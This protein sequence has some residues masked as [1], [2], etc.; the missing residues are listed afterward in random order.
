MATDFGIG[1]IRVNGSIQRSMK[2]IDRT[3]RGAG[4]GIRR[5]WRAH[6]QVI[7]AISIVV[8]HSHRLAKLIVVVDGKIGSPTWHRCA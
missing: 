4:A 2:D 6:N 7:R 5:R 1:F 3:E 8:G